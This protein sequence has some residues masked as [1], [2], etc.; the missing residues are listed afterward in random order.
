MR[1]LEDLLRLN[2]NIRV[3]GFDDAPFERHSDKKVKIAGVVCN[4]TRFEGMLWNQVTQDGLDATDRIIEVIKNSKFYDQ[5]NLILTDGLALGGFNIIDINRLAGTLNR[6]CIAVMRR[7]PDLKAV[8]QALTNFDDCSVRLA[9]LEKP[10]TF[11]SMGHFTFK[12][13]AVIIRRHR[14]L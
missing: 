14:S 13:P 6:P 8:H 12:T 2:K 10:A 7:S 1:S 11:T 9:L 4:N 5:V 3:I